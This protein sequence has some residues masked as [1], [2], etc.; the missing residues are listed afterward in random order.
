[1]ELKHSDLTQPVS[2][3]AAEDA[4]GSSDL[5]WEGRTKE[6]SVG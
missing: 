6:P 4:G 5:F 1:M 3:T 2:I